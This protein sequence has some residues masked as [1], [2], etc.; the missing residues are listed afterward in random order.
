MSEG[1]RESKEITW[2]EFVTLKILLLFMSLG[3]LSCVPLPD[4]LA[5]HRLPPPTLLSGRCCC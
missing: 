4:Q 5:N 3:P 2:V 1:G